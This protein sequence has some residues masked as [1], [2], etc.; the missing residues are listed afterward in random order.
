MPLSTIFQLYRGGQFYWWRKTDDPEKI[1]DLSQVTNILYHII[2]DSAKILR[3]LVTFAKQFFFLIMNKQEYN[4][5]N[6]III[7][8]ALL[9]LLVSNGD[10]K[11][12]KNLLGWEHTPKISKITDQ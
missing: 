2:R 9:S 8:F 6:L 10:R 3:P 11:V 5:F 7:Y 1:T 4:K 12:M